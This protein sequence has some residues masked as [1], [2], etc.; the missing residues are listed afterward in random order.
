MVAGSVDSLA[1]IY[2]GALPFTGGIPNYASPSASVV[3]TLADLLGNPEDSF[4]A[5]QK[6][7]ANNYQA[8]LVG[9]FFTALS[10]KITKKI[11]RKPINKINTKIFGKRG[12]IGPIGF[13][14]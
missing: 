12:L 9:S 8:I 13:K 10:Y 5:V 1:N 2:G 14:L 11:L 7:I 4:V 6:N 3:V